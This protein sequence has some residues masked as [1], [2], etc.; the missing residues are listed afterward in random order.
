PAARG[1]GRGQG[2]EAGASPQRAI[3]AEPTPAQD[4]RTAARRGLAPRARWRRCSS[5][6]DPYG[7]CSLVAPSHRTLGA[8]TGPIGIFRHALSEVSGM[9]GL[10]LLLTGGARSQAGDL[11]CNR[12]IRPILSDHCYQCH[13][14]DASA[15]KAKLRLDVREAAL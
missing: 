1:F 9:A 6:T 4:K 11:R 2:G 8:K 13:G 3:T 5:V 15:R 7:V 12:D 10:L 14:P